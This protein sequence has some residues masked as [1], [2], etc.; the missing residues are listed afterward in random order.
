MQRIFVLAVMAAFLRDACA[1]VEIVS[2][3]LPGF[4]TEMYAPKFGRFFGK[5]TCERTVAPAAALI[6]GDYLCGPPFKGNYT[7]KIVIVPDM[8]YLLDT[9]NLNGQPI[10]FGTA[11]C[12]LETKYEKLANAGAVGAVNMAIDKLP[13]FGEFL[14]GA[15]AHDPL[16][17]NQ[18]ILVSAYSG[19]IAPVLG[20]L[21]QGVPVVLALTCDDENLAIPYLWGMT[22]VIM[23]TGFLN[24]CLGVLAIMTAFRV[25]PS[26]KCC[27][28]GT[29][30]QVVSDGPGNYRV[31]ARKRRINGQGHILLIFG[32]VFIPLGLTHFLGFMRLSA[33]PI[34]GDENCVWNA[35]LFFSPNLG[36]VKISLTVFVAVFWYEMSVAM[37]KLQP[38]RNIFSVRKYQIVM[39]VL[40][41]ALA[42]PDITN[43]GMYAALYPESQQKLAW[44]YSVIN[45][46]AGIVFLFSVRRLLKLLHEHMNATLATVSESPATATMNTIQRFALHMAFWLRVFA[47]ATLLQLLALI[48]FMG[49][50]VRGNGPAETLAMQACIWPTQVATAWA[51]IMGLRGPRMSHSK[52]DSTID[53]PEYTGP[54]TSMTQSKL[55]QGLQSETESMQASGFMSMKESSH[56]GN[57]VATA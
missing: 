8:V 31:R 51:Q 46:I 45:A 26:L 40:I 32:F 30:N 54:T 22:A 23:I 4:V 49:F 36:G 18:T 25:E 7:G 35:K 10:K 41:L 16:L 21:S 24:M 11:F 27:V 6:P 38:L 2:P 56:D 28:K 3:Q 34:V 19:N 13:S 47:V 42:I 1:K 44:L 52:D 57:E 12:S 29:S 43:A 20:M 33:C 50:N 5:Q 14:H 15:K 39:I 9:V 17:Y 53:E 37:E 55:E 48:V